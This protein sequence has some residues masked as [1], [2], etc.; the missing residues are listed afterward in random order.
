MN[1]DKISPAFGL[2]F[3]Y[4]GCLSKTDDAEHLR[5]WLVS[6]PPVIRGAF[7][8]PFWH[9][10][11]HSLGTRSPSGFHRTQYSS[12]GRHQGHSHSGQF[13]LEQLNQNPVQGRLIIGKN[14][15]QTGSSSADAGAAS[16]PQTIITTRS[17]KSKTII[18]HDLRITFLLSKI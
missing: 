6:M 13:S 2:S 18:P 17:K 8:V 3:L 7:D 5:C 10:S 16:E 4:V 11:P 1:T 14:I 15:V 12:P 9:F